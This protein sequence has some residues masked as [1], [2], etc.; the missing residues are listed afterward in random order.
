VG[1]EEVGSTK[2]ET[3]EQSAPDVATPSRV[4]PHCATL[5]T[6]SGE[7]CPQCGRPF[8]KRRRLSRRGG[9]YTAIV[10]L[11][12]AGAGA[13]IVLKLNHDQQVEK[14][15]KEAAA[16]Q[17]ASQVAAERATAETKEQA[18]RS[19]RKLLEAELEKEVAQDAK[20]RVAEGTL[21][22]PI[23]GSS[24]TPVSGGSSEDLSSTAGTYSCMAITKREADGTASGYRFS[25]NIDFSTGRYSWHLGG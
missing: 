11:V 14:Q 2:R 25:A 17:H 13:G 23:L 5:S 1:D 21:E 22:G 8:V 6:S 16:A 18:E 9:I 24:C 3:P 20:K 12:L 19:T 10:V 4:C 15:R 7:F